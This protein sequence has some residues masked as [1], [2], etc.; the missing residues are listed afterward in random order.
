MAMRIGL[1]SGAAVIGNMGS[2]RRFDYTAMGDTIN[3]AARLEGA[4]KQY[5]V[6]ILVGEETY[7]R[8]RSDIVAREVDIIRVVGKTKPVVAYEIIREKA[9]LSPA[10]SERLNLYA[11]AREAYKRR[12]WEKAADIFGKIEGDALS[13]LYRER[14]RTLKQSPPPGD[15][16]GVIDLKS[17]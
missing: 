7:R 12:E 4:C 13:A 5:R 15:W 11:E 2:S 14:C 17:K 9:D 1:N 3:L 10:E 16:D 8:V 6:P